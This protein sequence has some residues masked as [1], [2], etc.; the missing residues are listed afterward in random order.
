MY[1]GENPDKVKNIVGKSLGSFQDLYAPAIEV[2]VAVPLGN[3]LVLLTHWG[4]GRRH[5][6]VQHHR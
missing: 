4:R 1:F 5:S 3:A 2:R 6:C